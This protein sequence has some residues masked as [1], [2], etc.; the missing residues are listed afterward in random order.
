MKRLVWFLPVF[1]GLILYSVLGRT[2]APL[3]AQEPEL[4]PR[5][6]LPLLTASSCQEIPGETYNAI[7]PSPPPTDRPAEQHADLNLAL[8]GYVPTTGTLGLVD[9]TGPTDH[10][11]PKLFSLFTPEREPVINSVSQVNA[12]DWATNSRGTPI[13]YP[14]ATL[15]SAGVTPDEILRVPRSE[16]N[17]GTVRR[18]PAHGFFVDAPNDDSTGYEVLVLYASPERITLKYTREDNVIRGYTVHIEGICVA[19]ALLALYNQW[20]AQGRGQLPA[21]K[22]GQAIGRA[23][24][25]EIGV[26][27]RDNGTFMDPRSRKD[28]WE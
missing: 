5:V 25:T 3:S 7:I 27:I 22:Q 13:P 14:P 12:W 17:I 4:S 19:P 10:K 11:G 18:V 24:G 16:Y 9:Y 15:L 26:V 6:F 8:R 20:N 23:I 21:L 1:V 28:W 2:T